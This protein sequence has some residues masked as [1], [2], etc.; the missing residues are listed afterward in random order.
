MAGWVKASSDPRGYLPLHVLEEL[1]Q[2]LLERLRALRPQQFSLLGYAE[3]TTPL[4]GPIQAAPTSAETALAALDLAGR[5]ASLAVLQPFAAAMD[6]LVQPFPPPSPVGFTYRF[7]DPRAGDFT[8]TPIIGDRGLGAG[9]LE[10]HYVPTFGPGWSW[11]RM[12]EATG[13]ATRLA[14]PAYH[15]ELAAWCGQQFDF[16]NRLVWIARPLGGQD[17]YPDHPRF[18]RVMD[19]RQASGPDYA[20]AAAA[21]PAATWAGATVFIN[22]VWARVTGGTTCDLQRRRVRRE[23]YLDTM[24]VETGPR[25]RI[26]L[27]APLIYPHNYHAPWYDDFNDQWHGEYED[28]DWGTAGPCLVR[29]AERQEPVGDEVSFDWFGY[30]YTQPVTV[31]EMPTLGDAAGVPATRAPATS[32]GERGYL[33]RLDSDPQRYPILSVHRYDEP[34]GFTYY[35]EDAAP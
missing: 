28:L 1:R 33:M 7:I 11:A 22:S 3:D 5:R 23:L 18:P 13:H 35:L 26:D 25:P 27:Y 32:A 30:P 17:G 29:I 12:L 8:G 31:V 16:L 19:D 15:H 10:T 24:P 6:W 21:W 14:L 2:A 20:S 4:F 34:G 9:S